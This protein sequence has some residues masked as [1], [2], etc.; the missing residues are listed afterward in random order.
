METAEDFVF[1]DN[2]NDRW[3]YIRKIVFR[4]FLIFEILLFITIAS[5]VWEPTYSKSIFESYSVTVE[6]IV[7]EISTAKKDEIE[8]R[9]K[10]DT[11]IYQ[12]EKSLKD[13]GDKLSEE[14]KASITEKLESLKKLKD[15]ED[16]EAIKSASDALSSEI[17]KIGQSVYNNK[18]GG[19]GENQPGADA[20]QGPAEP[21]S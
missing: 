9:N 6:K 20:G 1:Y 7:D 18:D 19:N 4:C 16:V 2:S 5:I 10:A 21:A 11:L 3:T 17:Q 15:S 14:V 12:A 13:A 8:A